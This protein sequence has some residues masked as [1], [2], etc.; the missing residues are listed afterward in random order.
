MI[1]KINI[2]NDLQGRMTSTTGYNKQFERKQ[3]ETSSF[4]LLWYIWSSAF[5]SAVVLK[6]PPSTIPK[7]FNQ[8]N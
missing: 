7:T 3:G 6:S 4:E 5:A 8:I 2:E 1:H